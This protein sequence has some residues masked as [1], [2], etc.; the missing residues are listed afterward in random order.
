MNLTNPALLR[1]QG[2]A[3]CQR[4]DDGVDDVDAALMLEGDGPYPRMTGLDITSA[5]VVVYCPIHLGPAVD[6][7]A[8]VG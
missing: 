1:T 2:L 3:T 8:P 4:L 7:W 6:P 5:A